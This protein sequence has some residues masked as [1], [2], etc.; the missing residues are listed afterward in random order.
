VP[1]TVLDVSSE[2]VWAFTIALV[3]QTF[4]MVEH[5]AQVYEHAVL[6]WTIGASHGIIFFLDFE[7]NH[8]LFNTTYFIA[9]LFVFVS[10]GF[11]SSK[12]LASQNKLALYA[13]NIGLLIQGYHVIEHS[14][15]MIQ[16]FQTGCTPCKGIL[17]QYFD[18]IYLHALINTLVYVL[19][20]LAFFLY[21][22][23]GRVMSIVR[24]SKTRVGVPNLS[25]PPKDRHP[26]LFHPQRL[27]AKRV[28][29]HRHLWTRA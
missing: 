1:K 7:W 21:G 5:V 25:V 13:F 24:R 20:L 8:F 3:A 12:G 23:L 14:V 6:G 9:L 10:C 19:P 28:T 29:V 26:N 11:Y 22:F 17:G 4:H 27:S 16:Y 2:T 18:G 15:R